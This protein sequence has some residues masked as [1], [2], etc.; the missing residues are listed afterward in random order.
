MCFEIACPEELAPFIAGKGS[1]ALDG[2]S[3]T[4]NEVEGNRFTINIIPHTLQVTTWGQ[5]RAGN[6]LNMEVDLMARYV[7]RL[8]IYD[9]AGA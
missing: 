2:T 3:L 7:A 1:V 4:V 8:G 9:R 5:K 6:V